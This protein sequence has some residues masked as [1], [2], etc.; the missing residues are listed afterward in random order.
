MVVVENRIDKFLLKLNTL[1]E[2]FI[3]HKFLNKFSNY[4]IFLFIFATILLFAARKSD[5]GTM[6]ALIETSLPKMLVEAT[7]KTL[8]IYFTICGID[9]ANT[10]AYRYIISHDYKG[11]LIFIISRVCFIFLFLTILLKPTF[12]L[13]IIAYLGSIGGKTLNVGMYSLNGLDMGWSKEIFNN[14]LT[15]I[16]STSNLAKAL[17]PFIGVWY[18]LLTLLV[19]ICTV[20]IQWL[21]VRLLAEIYMIVYGGFVMCGFVGSPLTKGLFFS[22]L[23]AVI[24]LGLRTLGFAFI[25]LIVKQQFTVP[26]LMQN[27]TPTDAATNIILATLMLT[28]V[29][30]ALARL[31]SAQAGG[32][33]LGAAAGTMFGMGAAAMTAGS[34]AV[35]QKFAGTAVGTIAGNLASTIKA[36]SNMANGNMPATPKVSNKNDMPSPQSNKANNIHAASNNNPTSS[37]SDNNI[38]DNQKSDS[39]DKAKSRADRIKKRGLKNGDNS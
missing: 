13:A 33:S 32:D 24:G 20:W 14:F 39:N 6:L 29:P 16:T 9:T 35:A 4:K 25:L 10:I 1:I 12:Y 18:G 21:F 3:N 2:S 38:Q 7:K 30:M 17:V 5:A 22:Y 36:F 28:T 23:T 19:F 15:L 8:V 31:A 27:L 26:S 11:M 37:N 34:S